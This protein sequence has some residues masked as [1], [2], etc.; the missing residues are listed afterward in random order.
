MVLEILW[1]ICDS[2]TLLV[3][4]GILAR[5]ELDA[6]RCPLKV[7]CLTEGVFQITAI[8]VGNLIHGVAVHHD[9]RRVRSAR[10]GIARLRS[11]QAVLGRC[12]TG[13][14]IG[15]HP[16]QARRGQFGH[17][18]AVGGIDRLEQIDQRSEEHTSELQSRT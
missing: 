1:L 7:E 3:G 9:D 2:A 4:K 5:D 11:E 14:G 16:R 12:L 6:Q 10:V 18:R 17:G 13:A 15:Q 8:T